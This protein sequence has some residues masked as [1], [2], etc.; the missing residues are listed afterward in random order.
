M[1]IDDLRFEIWEARRIATTLI[2]MDWLEG[3]QFKRE[4]DVF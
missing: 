1:I 2:E 3:R 4:E